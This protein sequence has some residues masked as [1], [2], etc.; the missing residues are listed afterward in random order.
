MKF[1]KI[2]FTLSL[3]VIIFYSPVSAQNDISVLNRIM[4]K[5]A[6]LYNDYPLEKVYLHFDKP[7]Y[8]IGDTIWFKAYLTIDHHQPSSL[9]KII[10]VDILGP[11]D[12]LMQTLKLQVKNSVAWGDI[13]L[14]QYSYKKGNYRVVAY[15]SYMN[16]SGIAYFFNKSITIGDAINNNISTQISLKSSLVN[17]QP[18][19]SAGIYYKDD[20]GNPYGDKKVNWT[21]QKDDEPIIKGKGTTDKNGFID[22][23]FINNKNY[24]LDSASIVTVIDNGYRKQIT[25]SFPLKS[26]ARSNDLQFF[27]EGGQLIVGVRTKVAFKAIKPSG[28]GIEL[29]GTITDNNNKVVTEFASSHLGM[30]V[31]VLTPE[32]GKTYSVN[33]TFADGSTATPDLPKIRSGGVDLS[34]ENSNPDVLTLKLQADTSFLQAYQGKTFFILAKASGVIYFAAKTQLQSRIYSASIPKN[35]FPTG[36]VQVTLFSFEGEPL[37]ERI[38]FIQHN[39][40]LNLSINGDHPTYATRQKVKLNITAKNNGQPDEGDFSIS[41]TDESKVPFDENAETTILTNLL[42]TSDIKGYIEK[43]NYYFNHPDEKTLADLDILLQTQGYRR[44]SY[45]GILNDKYPRIDYGAEQGIDI[46]GTLRASNGIPV[47]GGNVRLLIRDKNFSANEVT[48]ADGRFRFSKLV[49]LDSAK[50]NISARNNPRS[51]D[52]VL[53]ID[54]ETSQNVPLNFNTPD[55]ILNIDSALSPYL[56]NSKAQYS[57]LHILKEVVIK[58]T[59]IVKT[60]SHRDYG[61]LASLSIDPDHLITPNQLGGC[62]NVLDCVKALAAGMTFDNGN[63]YVM[64]DYT[65]GKRVPVQ[66]FLKGMPVDVNTLYTVN[67]AEIESIEIFLK[68][69]LGLINSAYGTNGAIV[70]NMK[71][72]ETTKISFQDLKEM[73][74]QP[75]ELEFTPKGYAAIRTFYLP[76]YSGPRQTQPTQVDTRSTIYWNPNVITDKTGTATLEYFNADGQGTYR[77]TVEGLDKDGNLGRQVY[78]YT[79]K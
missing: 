60:V 4:A 74:H 78:R 11:R 40:Q 62:A 61:S 10:Y 23:S 31:F 24:S 67:P 35:K 25:S 16:N 21:I 7:Y 48:D 26:V 64:R 63:F 79:V 66:I 27:P 6:K 33:V 45:D 32:E 68:D 73:L 52:L 34:L 47:K 49:F 9:S 51:S 18:K 53:T 30:G 17:K 12:T 65:S 55:E 77:V 44:F 75:N 43:P 57:N 29:K 19:I 38:A 2:F 76:R 70:V 28:L 46:T 54:G 72:V 20:Q 5:T 22:I 14:S 8:A 50:V 41:V 36:I 71:K 59:K 39:D 13:A 42:L 56:K 1:L 3:F 15:T 37:T 69:E 58:D